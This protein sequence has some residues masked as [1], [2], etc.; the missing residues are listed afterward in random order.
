MRKFC[1]RAFLAIAAASSLWCLGPLKAYGDS[2]TLKFTGTGSNTANSGGDYA[3]PY[4]FDVTQ[5]GQ[6]TNGVALMCFSFNNTITTGESWTA[7]I[8]PVQGNPGY[9]EVAWL[10]ND[11]ITH[12]LNNAMYQDA[13]WYLF[14][15]GPSTGN[16]NQ[17]IAAQ[18][19]VAANPNADLYSD[20]QIYLPEPGSQSWGGTPQ[21]FIGT[22]PEPNALLLFG[23]GMA[24]LAVG[25]FRNKLTV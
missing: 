19:F 14:A 22:T 20:F 12:P 16:N 24:L 21:S 6:T 10:L 4:Y 1:L 5:N 17:L 15:N 9:E 23:S 25:I 8:V 18:M 3:Y 13:A 7:D 2:V 11:A